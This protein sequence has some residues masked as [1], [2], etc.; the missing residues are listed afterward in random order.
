M[1]RMRSQGHENLFMHDRGVFENGSGALLKRIEGEIFG[2]FDASEAFRFV[3]GQ[4]FR[5]TAGLENLRLGGFAPLHRP[6]LGLVQKWAAE[7]VQSVSVDAPV[8]LRHV[9]DWPVE[10]PEDDQGPTSITSRMDTKPR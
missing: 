8:P 6:I 9:E 5:D 1:Y 10:V 2:R 3:F 4:C 7:M